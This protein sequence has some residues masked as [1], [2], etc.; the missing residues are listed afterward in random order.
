MC[1]PPET[2]HRAQLCRAQLLVAI[3]GMTSQS[4]T[5]AGEP[6]CGGHLPSPHLWLAGTPTAKLSSPAWQGQQGSVAGARLFHPS[7][8]QL[9]DVAENQVGS[10]SPPQPPC[11]PSPSPRLFWT[12]VT[13][14]RSLF[15]FHNSEKSQHRDK[16]C[17][18]RRMF[19]KPLARSLN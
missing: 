18:N 2:A 12:A 10:S 7:Q 19:S 3:S 15:S 1:A 17:Q 5:A 4:K 11:P 16:P 8:T 6:S 13:K 9:K 14:V